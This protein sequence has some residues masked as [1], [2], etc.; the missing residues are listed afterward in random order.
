ML[1]LPRPLLPPILLLLLLFRS[2]RFGF[3]YLS[4]IGL[5]GADVKNVIC[6]LRLGHLSLRIFLGLHPSSSRILVARFPWRGL[7]EVLEL[8]WQT[9]RSK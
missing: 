6:L 7:G 8:L 2:S 5:I 9:E 1:L 3:F 4:G